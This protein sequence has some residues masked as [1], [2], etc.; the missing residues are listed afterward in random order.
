MGQAH[1]GAAGGLVFSEAV[2]VAVFDDEAE[3]EFPDQGGVPGGGD[4]GERLPRGRDDRVLKVGDER[5]HLRDGGGR[6]RDG[7]PRVED[8]VGQASRNR[9]KPDAV[10]Q[11]HKW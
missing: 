9:A 11:L 5:G 1:P 8:G 10:R 2:G 6:G 7:D 3:P 4:G